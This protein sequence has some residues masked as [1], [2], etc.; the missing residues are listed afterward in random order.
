MEHNQDKKGT[1]LITG[2]RSLIGIRL[3]RHLREQGYRV[4][5]LT[6]HVEE[7]M[8]EC[9]EAFYWDMEER[10]IAEH[11]LQ[12]ADVIIHLAGVS[13][14]GER[15]TRARKRDILRSRVLSARLL[16]NR[17]SQIE[18]HVK[19]IIWGSSLFFYPS[20]SGRIYAHEEEGAGRSFL[21]QVYEMLEAEASRAQDRLG[22]RSVV[23]RQGFVLDPHGGGLPNMLLPVRFGLNT[24]LGKG[25]QYVNWIHIADLCRIY[26]HAI[27][28]E[29]MSGVYNACAEAPLTNNQFMYGLSCISG[30]DHLRI[31]VPSK[32]IQIAL[33]EMSRDLLRGRPASCDKLIAEG[34]AFHYHSLNQAL[35]AI[36]RER[37]MS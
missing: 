24:P 17:L 21:A 15:W 33:G 19:T 12:Q 9:D 29:Q 8:E 5:W 2:G 3:T 31:P 4:L 10:L 14:F 34:F 25:N 30:H 23:L 36:L 20:K 7:S 35:R 11:P 32:L 13:L 16:V 37:P 28:Q 27:E 6:R 22:V 26:T 18:H 1:I